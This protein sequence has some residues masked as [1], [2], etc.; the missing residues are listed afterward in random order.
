MEP[1]PNK[2]WRKK[3]RDHTPNEEQQI[4]AGVDNQGMSRSRTIYR[5][6]K[7]D[8]IEMFIPSHRLS[9]GC[10][11]GCLSIVLLLCVLFALWWGNWQPFIIF[12]PMFFI[13]ALCGLVASKKTNSNYAIWREWAKGN[14]YNE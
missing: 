6:L 4:A 14:G 7:C 9:G 1:D 11:I 12:E 13:G 3:C 8:G 2:P 5:C 10:V